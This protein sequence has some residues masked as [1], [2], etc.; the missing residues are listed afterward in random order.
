DPQHE[1]LSHA[2]RTVLD[3]R[4]DRAAVPGLAVGRGVRADVDGAGVHAGDSVAHLG[5]L[6]HRPRHRRRFDRL[7]MGVSHVRGGRQAPEDAAGVKEKEAVMETREQNLGF[8]WALA[9]QA[10]TFLSAVYAWMCAGL[11]VTAATAWFVAASPAVMRTIT[12]NGILFWG[13]L[14]AQ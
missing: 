9:D 6:V 5:A 3:V 7:W 2:R 1:L 4:I 11:A 8:R 13:L 14:I 12:S 10:S